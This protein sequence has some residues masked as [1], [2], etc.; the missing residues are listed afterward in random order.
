MFS[1]P[2]AGGGSENNRHQGQRLF[3]FSNRFTMKIAMLVNPSAGGG[4]AKRVA[5]QVVEIMQR[6]RVY[7]AVMESISAEDL[8]RLAREAVARSFDRVIVV[9]G[10][11]TWHFALNGLVDT[12][13]PAALIPCGRGNDF[14]RNAGISRN[15]HEAVT[16]ALTGRQ[17]DL[18]VVRTGKR[19]YIGVGGAGFDSE[20]TEYANTRIPLLYGTLA[21]TAAVFYKLFEFKPKHLKIVHDSGVFEGLVMFAVFGNSKSYGGGMYITPHADMT[22]GLIDVMIVEK[23]RIPN[24]LRTMPKVFTGRHIPHPNIRT[25]RTTRAELSTIDK[26]DLYGDGEYIAPLPLTLEIR[27]KAMRVVLP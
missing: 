25:F 23:I 5:R 12:G 2:F 4:R 13:V 9:G 11:G 16:T 15:I 24:L 6:Q 22:D 8:T 27:P 18:D 20:V 1:K 7:P 26:M 17:V 21:Y 10:D 14:R 19:H 3:G